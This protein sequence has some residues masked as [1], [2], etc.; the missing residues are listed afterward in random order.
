MGTTPVR[1]TYR[2]HLNATQALDLYARFPFLFLAY[3]DVEGPEEVESSEGMYH[4]IPKMQG[5]QL[6]SLELDEH[7]RATKEQ[8]VE[9]NYLLLPR[10]PISG[11]ENALYWKK[12]ISSPLPHP[13]LEP[14]DEAYASDDSGGRGATI[15]IIDDGFEISKPVSNCC[16][17]V[18]RL[19]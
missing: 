6:V 15:C 1:Q 19:S 17:H 10:A 3:A 5:D 7:S 11:G 13:S 16:D 2:T 4:A 8:T 9:S 18:G 12:M 14:A